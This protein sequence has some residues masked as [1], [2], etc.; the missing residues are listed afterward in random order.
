MEKNLS[1]EKL[2]QDGKLF[3][4]GGG[5]LLRVNGIRFYDTGDIVI[6]AWY[7][8]FPNLGGEFI[9]MP[10]EEIDWVAVIRQGQLEAGF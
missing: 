4:D 7:R 2:W 6:E 1:I 10:G 9:R 5:T 3:V 8:A